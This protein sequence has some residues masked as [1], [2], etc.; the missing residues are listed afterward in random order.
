MLK[1]KMF[2]NIKNLLVEIKDIKLLLHKLIIV[3]HNL[4]ISY[5][6]QMVEIKMQ[7]MEMPIT[8]KLNGG[9]HKLKWLTTHKWKQD[10]LKLLL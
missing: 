8:Q 1:M 5:F 4:L 9:G 7:V 6:Y 10:Q 2:Q 3:Q